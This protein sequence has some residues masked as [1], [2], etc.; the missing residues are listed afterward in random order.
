MSTALSANER[1]IQSRE[2]LRHALRQASSPPDSVGDAHAGLFPV[3]LIANLQGTPGVSVLLDL[4]QSWWAR[5]PA[6]VA[7]ALAAE[8]ATVVL[9][10]VAQRH[11]YG[12]VSG[13]AAVGALL[14]WV[15]PWRWLCTSALLAGVLPKLISEAVSR[16]SPPPN[17]ASAKGP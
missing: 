8:T 9:A 17:P 5:Q 13:A 4:A 10:P 2:Q 6:R 3:G 15:R 16:S 12:L 1:L 14:V 7:L 11:P